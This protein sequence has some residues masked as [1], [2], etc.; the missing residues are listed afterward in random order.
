MHYEFL[1]DAACDDLPLAPLLIQPLVENALIHGLE[2]KPDGGNITVNVRQ[3][4]KVMQCSITDTGMGF[5]VNRAS[6]GSG[7]GL[8]NVR[9]RLLSLYSDSA[10]LKVF[11][12]VSGNGVYAQIEIPVDT[13]KASAE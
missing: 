2:P 12:V 11:E 9:Q 4:N 6:A 8:N 5:A 3:S 10:T 13:L 7:L 1:V